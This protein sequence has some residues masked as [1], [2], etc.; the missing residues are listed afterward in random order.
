ML[1]KVHA[2]DYD[3]SYANRLQK[4]RNF[5]LSKN[6][7]VML[8]TSLTLNFYISAPDGD[9]KFDEFLFRN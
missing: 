4:Y 3:Q 2:F 6:L 8:T 5:F 1:S 9:P 7:H